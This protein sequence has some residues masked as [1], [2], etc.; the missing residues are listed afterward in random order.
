MQVILLERIGRLGQMGDVVRV[1]DGF[2]RNFLLPQGKALRATDDNRKQFEKAARAARGAQ[3]RAED[4]GRGRLDQARRQ[5]FIVHPPGRRHRP[6]LRLGLDP[7]HRRGDLGRR[8]HCRTATRSCST[9]RSRRSAL[10]DVRVQLHPEVIVK[11]AINVARSRRRPSARPA[12]RTSRW[13][14]RRRCR[15]RPSART[16]LSTKA[17]GGAARAKAR[18]RKK[19]GVEARGAPQLKTRIAAPRT[20]CGAA[21][22]LACSVQ[23]SRNPEPDIVGPCIRAEPVPRR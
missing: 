10:H 17:R 12:A 3:P 5:V 2:A 23:R 22:L 20:L 14:A 16:R 7:R 9:S 19:R 13:C 8:L 18:R 4:G 11:V 21:V 1:K 6:A 15:S